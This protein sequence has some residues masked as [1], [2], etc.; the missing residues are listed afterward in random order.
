MPERRSVPEVPGVR[1]RIDQT[2][3]VG[4]GDRLTPVSPL[5]EAY[6][7]LLAQV[8]ERGIAREEV[9]RLLWEVEDSAS[10]R[11]RLRQLNY[12]LKGKANGLVVTT[13]GPVV[14]LAESVAVE[15][16]R[17]PGWDGFATPTAAY[18]DRIEDMRVARDRHAAKEVVR[19]LES[20]RLS[21]APE[22]L[23]RFLAQG[24]TA[25]TAWRDALWALLRTGRIREA[26]LELRRAFGAN[27][28]PEGLTLGRRLA[29]HASK[30][31]NTAAAGG[32]VSIPLVGRAA[33][34]ERLAMLLGQGTP[35]IL[36]TGAHG[37]GRSRLMGHAVASVLADGEDVV[38][39][40]ARGSA[41]EVDRPF[42]GLSQL[43]SEE[44]LPQAHDELGQPHHEVLS[45]AL[46]LRF[47]SRGPH[48]LAQIGGPGSYLRVAQALEALFV[49]AFGS[50]EV[51]FCVDDLHAIDRSTLEVITFLLRNRA[52]RLLGTWCTEE[53]GADTE[54]LLRVQSLQAELVPL[55]DLAL[56]IASTFAQTVNP[57]ISRAE[58]VEIARVAGGRPGRIVDLIRA[59]GGAGLPTDR[60]PRLDSLLRARVRELR[61]PE[62]EV[63][64][65]LAVNR[66]RLSVEALARLMDVGIL[67]AAGH[68]RALEESGLVRIDPDETAVVPGLMR[69]FIMRELPSSV[70]EATHSRIADIL[71][72]SASDDYATIGH[73]RLAAGHPAEAAE[74]FQKA[75]GTAKD[76]TAYAEAIALLEKSIAAADEYDPDMGGDLGRLYFGMGDFE[77]SIHA[78]ERARDE[79]VLLNR[80]VQEVSQSIALQLARLEASHPKEKLFLE[81]REVVEQARRVGE[82]QLIAVAIDGWLKAAIYYHDRD[83]LADVREAF[84]VEVRA[85]RSATHFAEVGA[86]LAHLGL[87]PL[88]VQL[89]RRGY[90]AVRDKPELRLRYLNRLILANWAAGYTP[91]RTRTLV[92]AAE[93][94]AQSAGHLED[95]LNIRSNLG[96]W[97]VSIRP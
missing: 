48:H 82:P 61:V 67:E 91:I 80:P 38:L 3:Q 63:L 15:W 59:L 1:L 14:R 90:L 18:A 56:E 73:H 66:G 11:H 29:T 97:H 57:G 34:T 31:L 47:E 46:P 17:A 60:G 10:A 84:L 95:R 52:A 74:W 19:E 50:A 4:F 55:G 64:L 68:T 2:V 58:A 88:G 75:A 49:R 6:L 9:F 23:L 26:E 16:G 62:Q 42:G 40:G 24:R 79:F 41:N 71:V 92:G 44:T 5:E 81:F 30:L 78:Y 83:K 76:Q 7:L 32:E 85:T 77:N 35:S 27:V 87:A 43:L 51:I 28:P 72:E 70:R 36:L 69:D 12:K 13:R 54:L 89:V 8:G 53:P 21:D 20:A 86:R 94:L 39:L 93:T 37:V 45:R 96:L 22:A 33:E 25:P 65:L